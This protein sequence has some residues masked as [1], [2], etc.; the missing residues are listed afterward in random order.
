LRGC[1]RGV[2]NGDRAPAGT[3]RPN[4]FPTRRGNRPHAGKLAFVVWSILLIG[5]LFFLAFFTVHFGGFHYVQSQSLVTFF[6]LDPGDGGRH[7]LNAGMSTYV[8]V[9]R[10]Y[11]PFLPS[12]FL[13]HRAAFLRKPLSLGRDM[14]LMSLASSNKLGD[15]FPSRTEMS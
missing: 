13:A 11:W 2:E 3:L 12:A 9:A 5:A 7:A 10:R 1:W 4:S 8:E 6:P 14:S 15:L